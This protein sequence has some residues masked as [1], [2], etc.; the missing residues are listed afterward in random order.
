MLTGPGSPPLCFYEEYPYA[1]SRSALRRA[2]DYFRQALPALTMTEDVVPLSED[3][4]AAK[5]RA[6]RCYRSHLQVL[7]NDAAEMEQSMR[8][9]MMI[10]GDGTP[11][12]RCWRVVH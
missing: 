3:D 11:A 8:D 12:E 1:R 6:L 4:L 10:M 9:Y 2:H 7:W 5:L